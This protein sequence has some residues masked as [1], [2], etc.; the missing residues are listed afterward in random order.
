M[1]DN[2]H[3]PRCVRGVWRRAARAGLRGLAATEVG[4][5]LRLALAAAA[6]AA[7][8]DP[9]GQLA[10][11][12]RDGAVWNE[13]EI[14]SRA[15]STYLE[16]AGR[17]DMAYALVREGDAMCELRGGELAGLSEH[18]VA[19]ELVSGGLRRLADAGLWAHEE[20][21]RGLVSTN[22]KTPD[23]ARRYQQ[24]CLDHAQIEQLAEQI[25]SKP[26]TQIRAPRSRLARPTT[27]QILDEEIE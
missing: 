16:N 4:D 12:L 7:A 20:M 22:H 9:A 8:P 18:D 1:P 6:R 14:W 26:G 17:S 13:P 2:D 24:S 25:V 3:V 11:A 10:R 15:S 19:V 21:L 5:E 23:Q 27:E